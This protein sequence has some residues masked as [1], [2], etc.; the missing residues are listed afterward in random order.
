MSKNESKIEKHINS[1]ICSKHHS[2]IKDH[3]RAVG[4]GRPGRVGIG[5][6]G[7]TNVK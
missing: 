1:L 3:T 6:E 4:G 5:R 7:V 2:Y